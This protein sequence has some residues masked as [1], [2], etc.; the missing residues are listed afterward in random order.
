[1]IQCTPPWKWKAVCPGYYYFTNKFR[2][3]ASNGVPVILDFRMQI[4]DLKAQYLPVRN[5]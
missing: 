2:R 3:K 5:A 1:M 4:S